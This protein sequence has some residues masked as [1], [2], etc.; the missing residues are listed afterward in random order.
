MGATGRWKNSKPLQKLPECYTLAKT[1]KT[2]R[3]TEAGGS[4]GGATA[5]RCGKQACR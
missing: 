4:K 5:S 1:P 2:K 3:G